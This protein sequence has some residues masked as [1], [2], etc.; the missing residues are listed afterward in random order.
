MDAV[1]YPHAGV[2]RRLNEGFVAFR[3]RI[4]QN[5]SL[6]QRFLVA[7]TPGLLFM[8]DLENVHYKTF[9]WHPPEDS[10]TSSM[11]ATA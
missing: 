10:N 6:A 8:D 4:D 11:W 7:W 3:P 9:G 1:T 2:E 5:E